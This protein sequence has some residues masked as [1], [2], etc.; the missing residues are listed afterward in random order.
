MNKVNDFVFVSFY[1]FSIITSPFSTWLHRCASSSSASL[2]RFVIMWSRVYPLG[3]WNTNKLSA[4]YS[5]IYIKATAECVQ[6]M[7]C[8]IAGI[9][10]KCLLNPHGNVTFPTSSSLSKDLTFTSWHIAITIDSRMD[11][12]S[13]YVCIHPYSIPNMIFTKGK[14]SLL[15]QLFS[16]SNKDYEE[17]EIP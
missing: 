14:Y 6:S 16:H 11:V 10:H 13:V 5:S 2:V 3:E 1:S 4:M 15:R 12:I 7:S 9:S 8:K 17:F